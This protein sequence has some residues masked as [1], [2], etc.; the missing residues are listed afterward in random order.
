VAHNYHLRLAQFT[1]TAPRQ[2]IDSNQ[3]QQTLKHIVSDGIF[4]IDAKCVVLFKNNDN[5]LKPKKKY[6]FEEASNVTIQIALFSF[7]IYDRHSDISRNR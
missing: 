5:Y 7:I 1:L 4:I 6:F 3:L 2:G